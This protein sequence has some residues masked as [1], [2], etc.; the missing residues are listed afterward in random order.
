LSVSFPYL[1]SA[2]AVSFDIKRLVG[3]RTVIIYRTMY[4]ISTNNRVKKV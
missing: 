2:A 1:H 3:S 4:L